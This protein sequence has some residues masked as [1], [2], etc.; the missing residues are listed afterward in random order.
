MTQPPFWHMATPRAQLWRTALGFLL[1]MAIWLA[2]SFAMVFAG[3]WLL[4]EPVARVAQGNTWGAA[5]VFFAGFLG[6]HLGLAVVLPLLHRRGYASLFGPDRRLN[7]RHLGIGA[8]IMLGLAAALYALM[9][10]E[11]LLLPEGAAPSLRQAVPLSSWLAG[12]LP[13]LALI[14]VQVFA[15]E[16]L[17]RGYLLQQLRARFRSALIWGVAPSLVFGLLH[18][19]PG[20][21]GMSNA[22]AYVLNAT[23]MGTLAAFITLRTGNLGAA[24]GLHFGNNAAIA[25][26]GVSGSLEGFSL[27]LAEIPLASGYMTY[28]ILTQTAAT[29]LVFLAWWRWMN[30]HRPIANTGPSA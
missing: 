7:L 23:V 13:A 18:F 4:G 15:E 25:G 12:L 26:I 10:V 11:H 29:T 28:S 3:A 20:L 30:R 22:L 1:V 17:F 5:A 8:G 27:F 19:Q 6:F 2:V 16:A 14:F 21:Y 24:V 9:A